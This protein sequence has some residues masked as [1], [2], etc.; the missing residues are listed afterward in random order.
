M[1]EVDRNVQ[2]SPASGGAG[3]VIEEE[4]ID[5]HSGIR[6]NGSVDSTAATV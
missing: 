4:E 2:P 3:E 6:Y 1:A 5:E